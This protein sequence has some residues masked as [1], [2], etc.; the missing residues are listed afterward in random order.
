MLS[1]EL[2]VVSCIYMHGGAASTIFNVVKVSPKAV[3]PP[4]PAYLY[5]AT[6]NTFG[7]A[8]K[9]N[10]FAFEFDLLERLPYIVA[11]DMSN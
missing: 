5:S 4:P 7:I 1:S 11:M 2:V 8:L 9:L 10:V 6:A 3:P